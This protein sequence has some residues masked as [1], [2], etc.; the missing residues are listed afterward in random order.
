MIRW[1]SLIAL[2]V[3]V[4]IVVG[5]T[6][7]AIPVIERDMNLGL[8]LQGGVYVLLQAVETERS[9]VT[10]ESLSGT[11]EVLRNRVDQLGVTEPLIQQEG[12]DRIRIEIADA[13]Q[14]PEHVLELIGQTAQLEFLNAEGEVAFSGANLVDAGVTFNEFNQPVVSLELD[15]EG[16][17]IFEE[18]TRIHSQT[19]E[20][21]PIQLDGEVISSPVPQETIT[22]GQAVISGVGNVDDAAILASL[23]RSGALPLELE[24]LEVR[25]VGPELG[26]RALQASLY[27]GLFGLGLVMLFMIIFYRVPGLIAAFS[28]LIYLLLVMFSMLGIGVVLS[29]PGIAGLILTIGMA[30][31]ANVIIF[32]RIKEE[33]RNGKTLKSGLE[34][35]FRR[36]KTT[37]LDS[38]ITTLIVAAVLFSMG[39]GPIRGF[40]VTLSIGVVVSMFTALFITRILLSVVVNSNLIKNTKLFGV[41]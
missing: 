22:G 12:S 5:V 2:A 8:D 39:A 16:S 1:K 29:L 15:D 33:I 13:D 19:G 17:R 9:E 37:I 11:I 25:S 26:S 3:F 41:R 27:A 6:V 4:A 35:G 7:F 14:D 38:N 18:L 21:I 20:S 32:E 23:L 30:V 10:D 31:D 24:Q 28:L 40:A 36:A 34:S